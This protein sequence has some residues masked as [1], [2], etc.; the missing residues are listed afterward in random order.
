[1]ASRVPT[2]GEAASQNASDTTSR[3]APVSLLRVDQTTTKSILLALEL[4]ALAAVYSPV[5]QLSMTPVYGSIPAGLHHPRLMM[6]AVLLGFVAKSSVQRYIPR[7]IA[8]YLPIHAFLIPPIQILL[9]RYSGDFGPIYGPLI[10]EF[11][12]YFP[13]AFISIYAA[14][15]ALESLD[16]SRHGERMQ[17]SGPAIAS[18]LVFS[19][20]EKFST[21]FILRN[22][23]TSLVFTRTGLQF[24]LAIFYALL[25]PSKALLFAAFPVLHFASMNVHVPSQRTTLVLNATLQ[26]Y[27]YSL[28]ARQESLTGYISVLDNHKDGFRIMRCDHSLLGGEWIYPPPGYKW[29]VKDPIYSVFTTLEAVR[30]VQDESPKIKQPDTDYQSNALVMYV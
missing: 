18:Y 4:V 30:L 17:N 8:N 2:R 10:T 11:V 7:N 14:A 26:T 25:L 20:V 29:T 13:L 24:V 23:G 28:V 16:L 22:V 9:S 1:M 27:D 6:A 15:M 12:T 19:A 3:P 21:G 5:S